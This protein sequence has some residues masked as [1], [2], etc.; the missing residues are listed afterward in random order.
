[1]VVSPLRVELGVG[2]RARGG[3]GPAV[4]WP[5]YSEGLCLGLG[6]CGRYKGG[7][8]RGIFDARGTFDT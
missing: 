3:K 1:M 5:Q 6:L 4:N 7:D 2:Q 8:L